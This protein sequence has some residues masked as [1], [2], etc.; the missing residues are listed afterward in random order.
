VNAIDCV[1]DRRLTTEAVRVNVG[2]RI[3][4]RSGIEQNL[5]ASHAIVFGAKVEGCYAFAAGEC[6]RQTQFSI[7]ALARVVQNSSQTDVIIQ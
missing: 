1:K 6:T 2:W 4:I 5:R 7:G 3:D